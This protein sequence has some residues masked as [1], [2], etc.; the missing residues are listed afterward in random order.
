MFAKAK[1]KAGPLTI[2]SNKIPELKSLGL[3]EGEG[4]NQLTV[5]QTRN[6]I[7]LI[8]AHVSFSVSIH[9]RIS[10]FMLTIAFRRKQD[11]AYWST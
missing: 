8:R 10:L 7:S 3:K 2:I 1:I 9:I 11:V 5:N 4:S 6:L